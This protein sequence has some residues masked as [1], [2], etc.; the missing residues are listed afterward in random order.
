[1]MLLPMLLGIIK[2]CMDLHIQ[3]ATGGLGE[4]GKI[5]LQAKTNCLASRTSLA[6]FPKIRSET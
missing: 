1:M 2:D 5:V 3:H 6:V 4:V